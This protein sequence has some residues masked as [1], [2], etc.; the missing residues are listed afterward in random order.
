MSLPM[1]VEVRQRINQSRLDDPISETRKELRNKKIDLKIKK[2]QRIAI[3]AGSRGIANI[4]AILR[5]VAEEV[6]AVGGEPFIVPAMGSHGEATPQGQVRVLNDLGITVDSV[7]CPIISSME[8][9]QIG[10]IEGTQIYVDRNALR[11]D[12]IIVVGRVKP[13]TDFKGDIESG[14]MK[15]M[16]IGLGKQKGAEMIHHNL[17]DGYHNLLPAAAKLIM[18][19]CNILLGI[20]II[21]NAHHETSKI[22]ALD[23]CEIE[24]EEPKLLSEA[25]RLLAR[26]PFKEI[27]L[28]IVEE[29]GKNIS[30]VGM[31][32][33][34]TGRFWMPGESDPTAPKIN[35]IVVLDLTPETEGNALGIGLAD[36]TTLRLIDK[37]DYNSTFVNCLTQGT[38]ETGKT[39]IWLP[40]DR[41]AIN[42][43]LRLCGPMDTSQA[44][45]VRIHN[46]MELEHLWI[47]C[48]LAEQVKSSVELSKILELVGEPREMLFDVLGTLVR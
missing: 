26:L 3:T 29:I 31:D 10:N 35:K 28:L 44:S 39:P 22:V 46:T 25:K 16:A 6:K 1:M 17:F 24:A 40:N 32:T 47:S 23:S 15:M 37:I 45:I 33:N 41:D 7:G 21:E 2:D 5:T 8:V 14:L 27:D 48:K 43:A 9:D 34:V 4:S 30:G 19:K 13:H 42:A 12:G 36:L 20:A 11:A 38:C 18:D